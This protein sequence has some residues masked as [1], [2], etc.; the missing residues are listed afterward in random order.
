M[1]ARVRAHT[2][3][4]THTYTHTHTKIKKITSKMTE[5]GETSEIFFSP[6][7]SHFRCKFCLLCYE[8]FAKHM[9]CLRSVFSLKEEQKRSDYHTS[10]RTRAAEQQGED[11][12]SGR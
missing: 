5:E 12:G 1:H 3:T 2:H 10:V 7:F 6:F 11:I 4:H 8:D 9:K